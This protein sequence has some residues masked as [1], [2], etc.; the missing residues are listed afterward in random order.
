MISHYST[1]NGSDEWQPASITPVALILASKSISFKKSE[2]EIIE[3]FMLDGGR[4]LCLEVLQYFVVN[5]R[6]AVGSCLIDKGLSCFH[7]F[8]ILFCVKHF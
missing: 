7:S 6:G 1:V 8:T 3:V 2:N 5:W 4:S